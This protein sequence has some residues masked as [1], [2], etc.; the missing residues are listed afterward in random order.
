MNSSEKRM[1]ARYKGPFSTSFL[2]S[3]PERFFFCNLFPFQSRKCT[4]KLVHWPRFENEA[5]VTRELGFVGDA[6]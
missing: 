5:E 1:R 4:T 6:P 2:R 3:L